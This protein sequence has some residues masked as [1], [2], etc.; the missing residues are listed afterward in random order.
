MKTEASIQNS[1]SENDLLSHAGSEAST[2]AAW[3]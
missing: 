3:L 1:V 2:I